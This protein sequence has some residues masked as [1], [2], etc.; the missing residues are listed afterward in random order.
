MVDRLFV[1]KRQGEDGFLHAAVG[2]SGESGE[3]LDHIKKM[4]VYGRVMDREKV[5]EEM[6]DVVHYL[7]MLCIKL[8]IDFGVLFENNTTKL[9]KRYPDGF[10]R[11][12]A[13]ARAD[14]AAHT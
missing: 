14:Q 7:M 6:G 3:V 10:S 8:D 4:W 2:L 5:I 1:E 13:L 11:A 12:A 9:K